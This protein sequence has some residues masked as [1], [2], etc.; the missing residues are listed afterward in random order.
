MI[1]WTVA[2]LSAA[3]GRFKKNALCCAEDYFVRCPLEFDYSPGDVKFREQV[4]QLLAESYIK[5]EVARLREA[6]VEL[7]E[8]QLYRMLGAVG[9]IG[10]NWPAAFGGQ[11]RSHVQALI[12]FEELMRAGVPDSLYVNSIQTV[13]ELLRIAGTD[14]QKTRILPGMARGELFASVLYSEPE[15][16]S[17]LSSLAT[18]AVKEGDWFRLNGTKIFSLKSGITDIGL[19]AARTSQEKSRYAGITLFLI[20]MKAPRVRVKEL[21]ALPREQFY[22]VELDDLLVPAANVVGG[23]GEGWS[24]LTA[25]LP[26]E[27]TGMELALRAERWYRLGFAGGDD[28][29]WA[30]QVGRY[31]ARTEASRLLAWQAAQ[32]VASG[33]VD[34]VHMSVAKWYSGE[35]AADLAGWAIRCHGIDG[36]GDLAEA[37]DRAYLEAPG[38]TLSGGTSEMM[39]QLIAGHLLAYLG[40]AG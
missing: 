23:V 8:R 37:L 19:C 21:P 24:V 9:L 26:L 6:D 32:A 40:E 17:D 20:D 10:V 29:V 2:G 4:R 14:E 1:V 39:L 36:A 25:A 7:D 16:G 35:V 15:V 5:T 18:K 13:G 34:A 12:V 38:L 28:P 22:I 27:R 3:N 31:G 11:G 33:Q 30:E